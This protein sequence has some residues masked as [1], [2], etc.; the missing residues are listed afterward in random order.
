MKANNY[1]QVI[2]ALIKRPRLDYQNTITRHTEASE[3]TVSAEMRKAN[4]E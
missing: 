1:Y 4:G 2:R 3:T